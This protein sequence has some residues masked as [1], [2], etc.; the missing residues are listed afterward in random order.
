MIINSEDWRESLRNEYV[1]TSNQRETPVR[2][3]IKR[4]PDLAK[5]VF[6]KCISSNLHSA[7]EKEIRSATVSPEDPNLKVN[8]IFTH[9][10]E[11][12]GVFF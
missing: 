9:I 10:I 12:I 8:R 7:R 2:L 5:A 4:F 3:L 6:D 1:S 11:S